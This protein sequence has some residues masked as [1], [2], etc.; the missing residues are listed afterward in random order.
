MTVQATNPDL[1]NR[2]HRAEHNAELSAVLESAEDGLLAPLHQLLEQAAEVFRRRG[3]L[4][5]ADALGAHAATIEGIGNELHYLA[6]DLATTAYTGRAI[7]A[8][9]TS[10]RAAPAAVAAAPAPSPAPL[11]RSARSR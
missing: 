10:V 6:E 11:L 1:L 5:S 7:A 3:D 8:N 4:R 9:T 2:L